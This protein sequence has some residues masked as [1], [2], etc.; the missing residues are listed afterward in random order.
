MTGPVLRQIELSGIH[1]T[2]EF[3]L[4]QGCNV[5]FCSEGS[6]FSVKGV[7][8]DM[9]INPYRLKERVYH[10]ICV[11]TILRGKDVLIDKLNQPETECRQNTH[12]I[13]IYCKGNLPHL[14]SSKT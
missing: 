14:I 2:I 3:L 5:S 1:L 7:D 9:R 11:D 10:T 12:I 8:N 4:N 6:E 13:I